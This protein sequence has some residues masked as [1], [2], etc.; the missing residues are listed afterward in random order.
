MAAQPFGQL[1]VTMVV[2]KNRA[3]MLSRSALAF[4]GPWPGLSRQAIELSGGRGGGSS[5]FVERRANPSCERKSARF[6]ILR[7]SPPP[8]Q[9]AVQSDDRFDHRI[10]RIESETKVASTMAPTISPRLS[11]AM[12]GIWH[13]AEVWLS[14][15]NQTSARNP[16]RSRRAF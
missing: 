5:S 8:S 7:S 2:T 14:R 13:K 4:V 6:L 16:F 12:K 11:A 3:T 1:C 15:E 10:D 9:P